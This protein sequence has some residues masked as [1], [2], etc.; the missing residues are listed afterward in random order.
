MSAR[1][2]VPSLLVAF[3][4][5]LAACRKDPSM[6]NEDLGPTPLSLSYPAWADDG[7]YPL[8]L[9]GNNPLT[10]EGVALGRKLFYEKALSNDFTMSCATCHQQEH[11]F[12]DPRQFSIGT[13]G[14]VGRRNSMTVQNLAWDHVFFWDGR[15]SSL[16]DQAF[17]PVRDPGEMRNTWPVVVERLQ[18][19]PAYP[20]LFKTVFGTDVIDSVKVVMAIAQFERTLLSFDSP[21]D[22]YVQNG[23][24]S[25]LTEQQV[26]GMEL[27]F[28]D[29]HCSDCHMGPRFNDHNL[30][31]IGFG[32]NDPDLGLME[33][34]GLEEDR[35]R[36][37][38]VGLRNVAVTAPY[39]H[40]GRLAT[41][42]EVLDFYGD[43]V[44]LTT[45]NLDSHMFG[46]TLGLVD[47]DAEE[48]ADIVAFLHALTDERFLTNP[49]FS[50]PN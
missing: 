31:N 36:F 2:F 8:N 29:A 18:A 6:P 45:P 5:V 24:Q 49:A 13:D 28:G 11:A 50:D 33:V 4:V 39:M 47:L 44:D 16:E 27:F 43:D 9:P 46:W 10:V 12:S 35:G 22:R 38:N 48:R 26:R 40:N 23:D 41:L 19:H 34:T 25:A 7:V 32:Q 42:E 3:I 37:K 30:Q 21:Y 1:T 14:S 20:A 17:R 15:A